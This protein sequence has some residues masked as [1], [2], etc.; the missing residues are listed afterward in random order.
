[1]KTL[2]DLHQGD[3][4]YVFIPRPCI[5]QKLRIQEKLEYTS[6]SMGNDITLVLENSDRIYV[7]P[8][9]VGERNI[10]A[11]EEAAKLYR[12][13][14]MLAQTDYSKDNTET[15]VKTFGDLKIGDKIYALDYKHKILNQF[16]VDT[17]RTGMGPDEIAIILLKTSVVLYVSKQ[18][19][20]YHLFHND[21]HYFSNYDEAE[22]V[23][24][25]LDHDNEIPKSEQL[26]NRLAE[27]SRAL[28]SFLSEY[29][30]HK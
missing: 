26:I 8:S 18:L 5:V 27:I 23:F 10:F 9:L 19:T 13:S 20:N 30:N 25:A 29:T 28:N 4:V 21:T 24:L 14:F 12:E 16:E 3:Y 17:L 22:K 6:P 7:D 2:G 1:M 11:D 15:I